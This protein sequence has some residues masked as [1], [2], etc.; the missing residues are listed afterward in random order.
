MGLCYCY[1]YSDEYGHSTRTRKMSP[2]SIASRLIHVLTVFV[3]RLSV[4]KNAREGAK[5]SIY[6]IYLGSFELILSF[7]FGLSPSRTE[8]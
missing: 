1:C 6:L 5:K 2:F 8:I 4:L 3:L 7:E